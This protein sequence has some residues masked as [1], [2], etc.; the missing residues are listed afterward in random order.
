MRLERGCEGEK[1]RFK[2]TMDR[3][4]KERGTMRKNEVDGVCKEKRGEKGKGRGEKVRE[5]KGRIQEREA[6]QEI[7]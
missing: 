5:E 4:L 6:R 1:D 2:E 3:N 7:K